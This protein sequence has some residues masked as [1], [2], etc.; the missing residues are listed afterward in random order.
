MIKISDHIQLKAISNSD[1][2]FLF[3]LMKKIYTPAYQHFWNDAGAWYI[4]S[5]YAK[6]NVLKELTEKKASYY[7]VLFKGEIIGIFRFLWDEKLVG[8]SQEKQV[9]LH[10]IY[11]HQKVQGKGIGKELL[12]WL[13]EKAL[14]NKYE[15]IWLDAMNAH[16]NTFQF[17]KKLAFTYHSHTFLSFDLMHDEVRK[18]SQLYKTLN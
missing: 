4:N 13:E 8:L 9:K 17:Y 1:S 3:G 5:Q 11:L 15:V 2:D 6:E 12:T 16:E 7:F 18:I 10:R 14:Q